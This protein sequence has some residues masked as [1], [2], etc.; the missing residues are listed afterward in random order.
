LIARETAI[1]PDA[2][3]LAELFSAARPLTFGVEEEVMVLDE[4][5]FDLAPRARDALSR[6]PAGDAVKL[7]LPASQ[8]EILTP[9]RERLD[10]LADDLKRTRRRLARSLDGVNRI[11]A[12]GT[13]PFAA[14]EGDLNGGGTYE[15]IKREYGSLARR[16]LVCGLHL[17]VAISGQDRTLAVYNAMRAHLPEIAA[18][19]A[20]SPFHGGK[21]AHVASVRPLISAQLP[22]QGVPPA[23]DSW[24]QLADDL[25]WGNAASRLEGFQGW[26]WE[27]RLHPVFGTLEVRVPDAQT[28]PA[29]AL[30][31]IEFAAGLV[32]WLCAR[33]D[34]RDLQPPASGWRIAENR[35]SA[36]RDGARGRMADVYSGSLRD[37]AELLEERLRDVSTFVSAVGAGDSIETA[38]GLI[39]C[40]G[41]ERQRELAREL[42]LRGLVEWLADEFS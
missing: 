25:R 34:A 15:G 6:I 3:A 42:G 20:N 36:A 2:T 18:L 12:A 30:A 39:E 35:W 27:M 1:T 22:R 5:T 11:A 21:D 13:H 38:R 8:L 23:Y 29:E 28:R 24:K 41:A 33:H 32:L 26:W 10:E 17:H 37:T 4:Q 19:A 40:S 7:E 14:V 31:V 16:Q 9:P